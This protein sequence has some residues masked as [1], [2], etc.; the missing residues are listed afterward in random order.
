MIIKTTKKRIDNN[1]DILAL[2]YYINNVKDVK[3]GKDGKGSIITPSDGVPTGGIYSRDKY[4]LV[5]LPEK[6]KEPEE[7]KTGEETEKEKEIERTDKGKKEEVIEIETDKLEKERVDKERVD[8]EREVIDRIEEDFEEERKKREFEKKPQKYYP[9]RKNKSYKPSSKTERIEKKRK[10]KRYTPS[11]ETKSVVLEE[12][13]ELEES[14][15]ESDYEIDLELA[16]KLKVDEQI[17]IAK[18]KERRSN[19]QKLLSKKHETKTKDYLQINTLLS[20]KS[21]S[22]EELCKLLNLPEFNSIY[23]LFIITDFFTKKKDKEF[24]QSFLL[25]LKTE[26]PKE[27]VLL[28]S[29]I[30]AYLNKTYP[31]SMLQQDLVN[32]NENLNLIF[33]ILYSLYLLNPE[34]LKLI[35]KFL[36]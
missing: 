31:K 17:Y 16:D 25:N 35:G 32:T 23:Q 36:Q 3:D 10:L 28:M 27:S 14:S 24:I 22:K 20:S 34:L 26:L 33:S 21:L 7:D 29:K 12:L 6:K 4:P 30:S 15:S 13:K 5:T 9:D 1:A 2:I 11:S 18:A 19:L 8:R